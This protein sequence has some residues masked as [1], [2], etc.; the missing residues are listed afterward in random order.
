RPP[1]GHTATRP[2]SANHRTPVR[3]TKAANSTYCIRL[4]SG[5]D[6][7]QKI[8]PVAGRQTSGG[9]WRVAGVV[10]YRPAAATRHPSLA[11]LPLPPEP[12]RRLR[13][14]QLRERL[15]VAEAA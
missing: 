1:Y 2:H 14:A 12:E 9:G 7:Q 6:L 4:P 11:T 5:R 13:S 10:S 15:G 8:T 3:K